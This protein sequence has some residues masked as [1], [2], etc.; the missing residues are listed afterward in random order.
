MQ[1]HRH[2]ICRHEAP[3]DGLAQD[4]RIVLEFR[5]EHQHKDHLA[6]QLDHAGEQRQHLLAKALQ[7]VAGAQQHPQNGI[8]RCVP[9]QVP[10]TVFQ[11]DGFRRAGDQLH[12]PFRAKVH[13]HHGGDHHHHRVQIHLPHSPAHTVGLVC[14]AVLGN[15]GGTGVRHGDERHLRKGKQLAGSGVPRNGQGAKPVDAVLQ[16]HRTRRH[17]AAHQAHGDALAEQLPVEMTAHG[18]MLFLRDEDAH[19][20]QHVQNAQHHRDALCNDRCHRC[21]PHAHA[22][23]GNEP[24]VQPHVQH[25][26]DEQ[27]HQRHYAVANGAQQAC[28]QVIHKHDHNAKVDH[29]DV[30][31]GIFQNFCRGIQQLQQGMQAEKACRCNDQRGDQAND[32][33]PHHRALEQVF[34]LRAVGARCNNGKAIADTDTKA[35]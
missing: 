23:P 18:E 15:E 13:Q 33:R 17:D 32:D 20:C 19:P 4:D 21:A 28:A 2:Q 29:D 22:N 7:R 6:H 26:A 5:D 34:V 12:H 1:V 10:R 9:Q 27:E 31:V 25:R 11:H 16:H 35:D 30:A 8:E 14:A 3:D 24:Q